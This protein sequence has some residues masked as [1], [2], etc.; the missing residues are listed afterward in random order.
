M[1]LQER[2]KLTYLF[3]AHD[4]R[5]VR[6][7]CTRRGGHVSGQDRRDRATR[8]QHLRQPA[9]PVYARA[10][11]GDSGHRSGRAAHAHRARPGARS[12]ARR[13]C[14]RFGMDISRRCRCDG[15]VAARAFV[16]LVSTIAA[17]P[18]HCEPST[19]SRQAQEP[20]R[21][22]AAA[23]PARPRISIALRAGAERAGR[24]RV[25]RAGRR[26]GGRGARVRATRCSDVRRARSC[27]FP[28]TPNGL[29]SAT[30]RRS[31]SRRWRAAAPG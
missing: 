15:P 21:L 12:I 7:I 1:D 16:L 29:A 13:R 11:V 26:P 14:A 28:E 17:Q 30:C 10:A 3:I 23:R 9:A 24:R 27:G 2:L 22:D 31:T 4:L 8:A 19:V 6:H 20:L 18:C 25:L 5:L